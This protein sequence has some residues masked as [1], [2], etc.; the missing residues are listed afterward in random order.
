V[1]LAHLPANL[2]TLVF[3][4]DGTQPP[5]TQQIGAKEYIRATGT[6]AIAA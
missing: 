5:D 2:N 6:K 4:T 3:T 1:R